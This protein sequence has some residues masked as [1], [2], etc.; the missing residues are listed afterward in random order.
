MV[1][2]TASQ[3]NKAHYMTMIHDH[4]QQELIHKSSSGTLLGILV[5][6]SEKK[7]KEIV[8]YGLSKI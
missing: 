8:D 7:L 6:M 5:T 3:R 2:L 4:V 1:K